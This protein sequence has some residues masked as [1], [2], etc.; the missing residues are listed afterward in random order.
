MV[1]NGL[2]VDNL[3]YFLQRIKTAPDYY[4]IKDDVVSI[5]TTYNSVITKRAIPL[6]SA[7]NFVNYLFC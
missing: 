6:L 1:S 3:Q 4:I 2:Q 5:Y 7:G